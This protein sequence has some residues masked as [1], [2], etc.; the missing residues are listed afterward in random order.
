MEKKVGE[1]IKIGGREMQTYKKKK[2]RKANEHTWLQKRTI[3]KNDLCDKK[4][5]LSQF[6]VL[7][8]F[9]APSSAG[10]T[11]VPKPFMATRGGVELANN[12]SVLWIKLH[13]PPLLHTF[14]NWK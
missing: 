11:T 14:L 7:I 13:F 3:G 9:F 10:S 6:L 1:K 5:F 12:G 2:K 4:Y 8:Y